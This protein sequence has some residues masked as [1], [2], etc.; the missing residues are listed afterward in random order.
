M[1]TANNVC[2]SSD[3]SDPLDVTISPIANGGTVT[4]PTFACAGGEV[5][6]N[7]SGHF[8]AVEKW[9]W[10]AARDV[11]HKSNTL[12]PG[13]SIAIRTNAA[14]NSISDTKRNIQNNPENIR[15]PVRVVPPKNFFRMRSGPTLFDPSQR[16]FMVNLAPNERISVLDHDSKGTI[17]IYDGVGN[18]V[19]LEPLGR[20]RNTLQ[21]IWTGHNSNKRLV[22]QGTY[23]V[24]VDFTMS[25]MSAKRKL[26]VG[27]KR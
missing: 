11:W 23:V 24:V 2:G 9:Q 5:T 19:V 22:G 26:K 4:G 8:G 17:T 6:L 27:V 16:H 13:D 21:Y 14:G 7:V 18:V 20:T 15:V 12:Q 10:S 25:G 3:P 1:V